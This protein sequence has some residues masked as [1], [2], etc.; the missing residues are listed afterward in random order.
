MRC[1]LST[2]PPP[3]AGPPPSGRASP[4]ARRPRSALAIAAVAVGGYFF[5]SGPPSRPDARCSATSSASDAGAVID[6]LAGK[7]VRY[8]LADGGTTVL[9]PQDQ[10]YQLRL[11]LSAEGLP[12]AASRLRA[13]RQAG[14]HHLAS[15]ASR[16]TTS[17]RWKASWPTPSTPSTAS[18]APT[19]TSSSRPRTSSPTT[20]AS[21]PPPSCS[22]DHAGQEARH[23]AGPGRS[24]TWSPP[25]SRAS[26]PE[27][28]TVADSGGHVLSAPGRG[29][30]RRLRRRPGVSRPRPSRTGWPAASRRCWTPSSAP[31]AP[32]C[33]S[34]PTS[35]STSGRPP[36]SAST[37]RRR[38]D[39]PGGRRV[40]QQRDLRRPGGVDRRRR[41]ARATDGATGGRRRLRR[42]TTTRSS[43][44]TGQRR[45]QGHRAGEVGAR[46]GVAPVGRRAPRRQGQGHRRPRSPT[47]SP[48]PP[49]STP[50]GATSSRS[51]PWPSTAA[52]PRPRPRRRRPTR[53]GH[54]ARPS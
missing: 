34:P 52:P 3:A 50:A 28:V 30:S 27:A 29:R 13:A 35:T 16:S 49:A 41:R 44:P 25:A 11:D 5:T 6:E 45:R 40:D 17:G 1:P 51:R 24:S 19:C 31:A 54:R 20:P 32:S 4:P 7:G 47:W 18:P 37:S 2:S 42:P 36:P 10:V 48:P 9:V 43:R 14:H 38:P 53:R 23:R 39:R 22:A 15:S 33:R 8:E 26:S 21:P 46:Q 12:P